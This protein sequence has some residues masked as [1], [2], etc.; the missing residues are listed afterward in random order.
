MT[1]F[2][3]AASSLEKETDIFIPI[4]FGN[5]E[6]FNDAHHFPCAPLLELS[7]NVIRDSKLF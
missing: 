1:Q 6:S 4:E 3:R 2:W 7:L 5:K